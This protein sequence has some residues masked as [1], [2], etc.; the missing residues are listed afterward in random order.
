MRYCSGFALAA[1]LLLSADAIAQAPSRAEFLSETVWS[2]SFKAFGGFSGIEVS[3]DGESFLAIS[4][5]GRIAQGRLNR[6]QGLI[7]SVETVSYGWLRDVNGQPVTGFN[8]D[9]EGLAVDKDGRILV[10]FEG[11]HRILSYQTYDGPADPVPMFPG[12]DDLQRN[13]GL[14]GLAVDARGTLYA[15]PERSGKLDRPFPVYRNTAGRWDIAFRIPRRGGYLPVG[16][17]IDDD[18]FLYLLERELRGVFFASRLRR[19][20][21][22]GNA[23]GAEETIFETPPARHGNLEGISVWRDQAGRTR[24]TMIADDNFQPFFSTAVVEYRLR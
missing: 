22:E 8:S 11:A 20:Q 9:A 2:A 23:L 6:Q 19:F 17:D 5:R 14:E 21:I 16:L 7:Q 13:S 18:G 10:S 1:A 12:S 15:L 3:D 24:L 4:D